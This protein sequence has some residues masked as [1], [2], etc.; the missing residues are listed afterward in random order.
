VY[1]HVRKRK[2]KGLVLS[3]TAVG[4]R[5]A[6]GP[7][8]MSRCVYRL[9]SLTVLRASNRDP[10]ALPPYNTPQRKAPAN[11]RR[12]RPTNNLIW[13]RYLEMI[14]ALDA[15]NPLSARLSESGMGGNMNLLESFTAWTLQR[16][17]HIELLA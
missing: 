15:R 4:F 7:P 17:H 12:E 2:H 8:A 16:H 1:T 9:L 6:F 13:N 11:L 10:T 3:Q 14:V 5:G